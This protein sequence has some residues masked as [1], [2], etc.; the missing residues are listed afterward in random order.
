MAIT[1]TI[2]K[3]LDAG[4]VQVDSAE[5]NGY[6]RFYKVPQKNAK[7]FAN[8]LKQQ[9]KNLNLYSNIVFFASIFAGVF[10]ASAFTKKI[11]SRMKQFLIQTASAVAVGILSS[12]AFGIYAQ[13][14]EKEL[15]QQYK[16][17]EIFYRA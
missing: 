10:G 14:K 2:S 3:P 8:D 17:K 1:T 16:A 5:K 7:I 4:F 11:E 6:K 12:L 9:N 13:D 15:L